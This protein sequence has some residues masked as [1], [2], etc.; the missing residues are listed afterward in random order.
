MKI[1]SIRIW[2]EHALWVTKAPGWEFLPDGV[3]PVARLE[4]ISLPGPGG[5]IPYI[6]A[7]YHSDSGYADFPKHN[8]LQI[9]Y[10]E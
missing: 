10:G 9:E 7:H 8:L 5:S 3:E 4:E 6:R 2:G 1:C